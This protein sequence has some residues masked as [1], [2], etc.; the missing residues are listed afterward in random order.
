MSRFIY[1]CVDANKFKEVFEKCQ[2]IN[3]DVA[4]GKE[5]EKLE[6]L[7]EEKPDEASDAAAKKAASEKA[8]AADK[9]EEK[10]AA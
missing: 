1:S 7:K 8:P 6:P 3:Q 10:V 9:K 4:D 5:P 2:K